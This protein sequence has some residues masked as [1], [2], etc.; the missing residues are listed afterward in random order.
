MP[1]ERCSNRLT[2]MWSIGWIGS[3]GIGQPFPVLPPVSHYFTSSESLHH[4]SR[5]T[6]S[7]RTAAHTVSAGGQAVGQQR[8]SRTIPDP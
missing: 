6:P 4:P 1:R 5:V 8:R 2:T 7:G 3:S